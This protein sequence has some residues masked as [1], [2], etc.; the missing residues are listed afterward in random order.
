MTKP[1]PA[2]AV[3]EFRDIPTGIYATDAMLKKAPIAFV[4]SGTIT[5]GR[6][7]TLIGGSTAS[8]DEAYEEGRFW[9][10]DGITDH[11]FLPDIDPQVF[12]AIF[13][14]RTVNG[15]LSIAVVETGSVPTIIRAAEAAVKGTPISIVEIRLAD[16]GL[17]GKGLAIFE[18]E[19]HDIE[20]AVDLAERWTEHAGDHAV[21]RILTRPHEA[22]LRQLSQGTSFGTVEGLNLEGEL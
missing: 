3:V 19:L 18:G 12:A 13:K 2:V 8:V 9:G 11:V 15:N 5:R 14:R 17:A 10:A 4:K 20:A 16:M 22:L 21:S 6:F 1:F 7:L